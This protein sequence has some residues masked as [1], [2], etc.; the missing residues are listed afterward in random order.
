[1]VYLRE[2][3]VWRWR[4]EE[5]V[6]KLNRVCIYSFWLEQVDPSLSLVIAADH[7]HQLA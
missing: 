3:W 1:M 4:A 6:L 5:Q 7:W 2:R